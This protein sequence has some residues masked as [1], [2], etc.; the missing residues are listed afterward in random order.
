VFRTHRSEWNQ[1]LRDSLYADALKLRD[2]FVILSDRMNELQT[3][4]V[5]NQNIDRVVKHLCSDT[6]ITGK[7]IQEAFVSHVT[8][9]FVGTD[10]TAAEIVLSMIEAQDINPVLNDLSDFQKDALKHKLGELPYQRIRQKI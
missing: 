9:E 10:A 2:K 6:K 4:I 3:I 8:D 1:A 7:A 5:L